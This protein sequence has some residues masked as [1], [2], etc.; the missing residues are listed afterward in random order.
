MTDT[1]SMHPGK[2]HLLSPAAT[3]APGSLPASD[4]FRGGG[5]EQ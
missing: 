3:K 2:S 5:R 1:E 4:G